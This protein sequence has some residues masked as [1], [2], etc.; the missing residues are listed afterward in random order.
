MVADD[1]RSSRARSRSRA[2]SSSRAPGGSG[3]GAGLAALATA[4]LGAL[5]G[6]KLLDRSRSRS[7]TRDDR[8][9]RDSTDSYD[10]RHPSPRRGEGRDRHRRSKSISDYA[11]KGLAALGIGEGAAAVDDH[12]R[13]RSNVREVDETYSRRTRRHDSDDDDDYYRRGSP[14]DVGHARDRGDSYG[15]PRYADS[16]G[17]NIGSTRDGG[18][19]RSAREKDGRR[20]RRI[21]EGKEP[22]SESESSLGSSSG[23]EKRIKKMKGKQLLTAGLATVATI[24]A[25]H[26]IY[27]SM[28]K[29]EARR[30]AVQE[31]EMTHEE[32]RKLKAKA[33]LQDAASV[34]IAALGIRGAISEIKEVNELRHEFKEFQEKKEERHRKRLERQKRAGMH[35]G[36]GRRRAD[37]Y[38]PPIESR[39]DDGPRYYDGNPY[40]SEPLPAPPVGGNK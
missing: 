15:D 6:K 16:L 4:G 30:K 8:R 19:R 27:Q 3:S 14:R 34:G 17:S 32:A 13:R 37:G 11:R 38:A 24:H 12:D 9:R 25:A 29:R 5:A 2:R 23:D 10:D 39:Y 31:G 40:S 22:A 33:T 20:N 21:A 26:N 28:E 35:E 18:G 1:D 36:G 7:R